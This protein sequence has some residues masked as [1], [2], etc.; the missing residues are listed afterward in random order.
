[1]SFRTLLVNFNKMNYT[2]T[3][4]YLYTRLPLFQ[5]KG[6]AAYKEG[7]ENTLALDS[8][9]THPHQKYD[10]IHVAGTN[11]KG[12]CSHTLAAILQAAG[13]K[14]G[15]YTSPH[16]LDFRERIRVN[17]QP[18]SEEFVIEFVE[19]GRSFFEPLE[20]SF[21]EV[22]TAMAFH[23]FETQGVDV[24]VIE[25]GLGGRLDCTNIITPKL[26]I[27]TNISFDHTQILG[28]TLPRIAEEKAGIIKPDVPVLIGE[29]TDEIRAVFT[30]KAQERH[31][32]LFFAEENQLLIQA[33]EAEGGG[34][35]YCTYSPFMIT[36][37]LMIYD[38]PY[39][40]QQLPLPELIDFHGELGGD[41]QIKNTETILQAVH[42]LS[43][44]GFTLNETHLREG[45][46][47]VKSLTGL[48]GR[49]E[50][51]SSSPLI[52]CDTGH[53]LAGIS[54]L[55]E[56]LSRQKFRT[57]RMVIGMVN[58]KDI[59]GILDLLPQDAVYYF[60]QSQVNRAMPAEEMAELGAFYGLKGTYYKSVE[61]AVEAA[62][63]DAA[64][65]DFIFVG[66]STFIV[67]DLLALYP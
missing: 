17:G 26:S 60:T 18:V 59:T 15:L 9:Y 7:L 8:Y 3:L 23:Y 24:A 36:E 45:F 6:Q 4:H 56:Q 14:V 34:W 16:L 46:S 1:M 5:D 28:N 43:R 51:I 67:A 13:Y 62:K 19:K 20:A 64:A 63:K 44:N 52:Y 66:G 55:V 32:P 41:A 10:T 31:A 65:D 22:T 29:I 42:L 2:Q 49:W 38:N 50:K 25:T 57:L 48:R 12:S 11:G 39:I 58:D 37:R 53:N 35:N 61:S 54:Y 27:I 40:S 21:F 47:H 33:D 30:K